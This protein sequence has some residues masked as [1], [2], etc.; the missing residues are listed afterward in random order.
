MCLK[1]YVLSG[2]GL[3]S[4]GVA[5]QAEQVVISEILYHPRS[6]TPEYLEIYNNTATPFDMARWQLS[7]GVSF[8]FP[9]FSVN[10]PE[11]AFLKPFE[12]IVV[13]GATEAAARAVYGIRTNVRVFGP[14]SGNLDNDGERVTLEDK[15]GTGVCTVAYGD[16]GVWPLAADGAGHSLV[17]VDPDRAVDDW[18][19]WRASDRPGGTPGTVPVEEAE[20]PVPNPELTTGG[21]LTVVDFGHEWA[22]YDRAGGVPGEDWAQP[23]FNLGR[24]WKSGPGLFGFESAAL[25]SPGIQS[26]MS[27][28]DQITFYLRTEFVYPGDP[29]GVSL[30]LDQV[31]D[32]GAVY[33]LNGQEIGR[34]R[35]GGG[36]VTPATT[37][38]TVGNAVLENNVF[39]IDATLLQQGVNLL[40]VEVH[41]TGP[42]SSD[43]VFGARLTVIA[44]TATPSGVVINEILPGGPGEG[45]VEFFNPS[46]Q[47][48]NLQGLHLA[49]DLIQLTD[50]PITV[51]LVISPGGFGSVGFAESGLTVANPQTLYLISADGLTIENGIQADIPPDGRSLGRKPAGGGS[52]F[53]FTDPSRDVANQSQG[54]STGALCLNEVHFTEANT[55]GWVELLNLGEG[56]VSLSGLRLAGRAALTD[57]VA[58]S[59]NVPVGGRVSV[60]TDFVVEDGVVRLLLVDSTGRV[61]DAQTIRQPVG[62]DSVQAYPEGSTEWFATAQAT[63]DAVNVP[64]RVTDIVINEVMLDPPSDERDGEYVELFNRGTVAVDLT[65]WRFVDGIDFAFPPGTTIA[66]GEYVVVAANATR[67]R[68]T[69]G[70]L[71]VLGDF[72]GRLDNRGERLRLAD[73][74]GNLADEVDFLVGGDWP[75][76]TQG[77]G[78]SMELLNPWMDNALPSAWRDSDESAKSSF[79]PYSTTATYRQLTTLGGASDYRELHFHLAGDGYAILQ[80]IRFASSSR[81]ENLV[82]NGTQESVDNRSS[83]GWLMQGTH[84]ASHL[85]NGQLHLIADGHGDNR[86]NRAEID[87][88]NVS[89]GVEYTLSFDAR[90]VHGTP[91][92]I[93][94]TWDHSVGEAFRLEVPENLGSPGQVNSIHQASPAPQVDQVLHSPA[95]PLPG[96][97]VQVTARVSSADP[98]QSVLLWHRRDNSSGNATWASKAMSDD[99]VGAG[100]GVAGDGFFTGELTEYGSDGTIVQ[101]F[102]EARTAAGASARLPKGGVD[103]PA[104]YVVDDRDNPDDLRLMRFVI[105]AHDM[106]AIRNGNTSTHDYKFP[107]LSNHYFNATLIVNESRVFYSAEIRNSGSPWTRSADLTRGKWKVP[108]DRLFRNHQKQMF[109]NDPTA[110]RMHNNRV[111]RYLLYLLGHPVNENEFVRMVINSGS[112]SIKEETEPLG[113]DMLDRVVENGSDGE[114]YRIDDEWWFTDNWDQRNRDADWGYKNDNRAIRYHTEWMRRTREDDYDYT[115]LVNLFRVIAGLTGRSYTQEQ[116]ERLVDAEAMLVMAVVRGYIHD[117]DWIT[118]NRGKNGYMYRRPTDGLFQFFHWDS[119]LAWRSGDIGSALY[120]GRPGV[121]GW[122]AKPYNRRRFYHY[123]T[124]L[125]DHYTRNSARTATWLQA[126]EDANNSFPVDRGRYLSWFAGRE[127]Y[128]LSAMGTV[129]NRPLTVT[130]N[131]GAPI[132]TPSPE[133]SLTGTAS[134]RVFD[135]IIDGHP[136]A[137]VSWSESQLAIWTVSDITLRSGKEDLHIRGV[138]AQGRT[139]EEVSFPVT[140]TGQATPRM[141]MDASPRSWHVAVGAAVELDAQD[142]EDPDAS[143]LSF[144]WD[145]PLDLASFFDLGDGRAV[146]TFQ[147]PGLYEFTVR[148]TNAAGRVGSLA[149][150]VSVYGPDGFSSFGGLLLESFWTLSGL[151]YRANSSQGPW[152]TLSDRIGRLLV[153]L[154][155]GTPAVPWSPP[156]VPGAIR[157][158]RP[159]PSQ[160]DWALETQVEL[161]SRQFGDFAIGL[162]IQVTTAS[163][164]DSYG[165]VMEDGLSLSALQ[166]SSGARQTLASVSYG[167]GQARI[168]IRRTDEQLRFETRS[169]AVWSLLLE[170]PLAA[171]ASVAAGGLLAFT[172]EPQSVRFLFDYVMLVDPSNTSGLRQNLRISEIMYHPVQGEAY[173]YVELVNGGASTLQLA[174]V[175]FVEGIG[176]TFPTR[177]LAAGARVVV[178]ADP[179]ALAALY[180]QHSI[181]L[182]AG[183]F[184]GRLDNG[185]ERLT[186][187]DSEGNVIQSFRYGDD[188]EWPARADGWGASLEVTEVRGDYDDPD[189]WHSSREFL[190]SPGSAGVGPFVSV[191]VNEVLSHTDPPF[192]DAIEL[193]NPTGQPVDLSGW[194]L[195]DDVTELRKYRFPA[196]TVLAAGDYRVVYEAQLSTPAAGGL[197]PFQLDSAHGDDVWLTAGDAN[198]DLSFFIDH[199]SFGAA[200]N[201]VSFGRF[202]DGWGNLT[203]M[204]RPTF[205]VEAPSSVDEF[206]SGTGELNSGPLVGPVVFSQIYYDALPGDDEYLELLNITDQAVTLYDV[207]HSTNTW[208]LADGVDFTFP[209]GA[210]LVSGGR[211]LVVATPVEDYLASHVVSAGVQV[212]GPFIGALDNGGEAFGLYRPDS[213]QTTPPDVGYVPQV[214]VERVRYNNRSP[215]P[216]LAAGYGAALIR[217]D[218]NSFGNDPANWTTDLDGDAM[219]DDWEAGHLLSPFYAGDAMVDSDADGWVNALEYLYDTDPWDPTDALHVQLLRGDGQA[220]QIN[221]TARPGWSYDVF[222]FESLPGNPTLL[223]HEPAADWQRVVEVTDPGVQTSTACFYQ[224]EG[225]PP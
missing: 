30:V 137:I 5:M 17:L 10:Y 139:V 144:A 119:D 72:S 24:L 198:G 170:T 99:G 14:W 113:N 218:P 195:S 130:S 11:Q 223:H 40:A 161:G 141:A 200:R 152:L 122:L 188:G 184:T 225:T 58:L 121:S 215:W 102:V 90:W 190:G 109:D 54:S 114:L 26:P 46:G 203:P 92:L 158:Q 61:W 93:G 2:L 174:G 194:Y 214:L 44:S 211:L 128:C 176:Y 201:G 59:G 34:S 213:P 65:G 136:E 210:S 208:R 124:L 117:W 7:G 160:G 100:D 12:R 74:Y 118:L 36:E 53:L 224:V 8:E 6:T 202:P 33:Y 148:A 167:K 37:A 89:S 49:E 47:T 191:V 52:W 87:I 212:F 110:G 111:T 15:N 150:E 97:P 116:V 98:L 85:S 183:A 175:Q 181:P 127:S 86:A 120:S 125:L 164:T 76:L 192:E 39:G 57:A 64:D 107:R 71:P 73:A 197:F 50:N 101:F 138:D 132:E 199:V 209:E 25:P 204:A 173:E 22:F 163:G 178:A 106:D 35:I 205:G 196:D 27:D 189:N 219:G 193:F 143:L 51:P 60:D 220:L 123:L 149:R 103:R 165:L 162:E 94:Q 63:R 83:T 28:V 142:S 84:W 48:V 75:D 186:L 145:P 177:A 78:S 105:S 67:L 62:R 131:G 66:A 140:F 80:N 20:T 77:D 38:S 126:E 156:G 43:V 112:P 91:R 4:L 95:V 216:A 29:A 153:Q 172:D 180:S 133:L 45:F 206:R 157:L 16:S 207:E 187:V 81:S 171:D 18:R 70:D 21:G 168:R 129:L 217:K 88:P 42:T 104:L 13:S 159:M 55:V 41:Q 79:G 185:G 19:N 154:P 68:A 3:V 9:E 222:V 108:G 147:R 134:Y 221:F 31:L 146:A 23:G 69:H 115:A 169:D 182:A 155:D 56:V 151:D 1:S 135:L 82:V 166:L 32:D 96:V 179:V